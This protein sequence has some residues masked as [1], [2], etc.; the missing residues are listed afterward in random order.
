MDIGYA[1]MK[2]EIEMTDHV[3]YRNSTGINIMND[4]D[5]SEFEIF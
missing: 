3:E 4:G 2:D 5:I 1:L